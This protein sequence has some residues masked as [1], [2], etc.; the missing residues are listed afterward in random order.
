ME[1]VTTQL[2]Q[3]VITNRLPR[4]GGAQR[5][6]ARWALAD[7]CQSLL[8]VNLQNDGLLIY[9]GLKHKM[10]LCGLCARYDDLSETYSQNN[11]TEI[12]FY[13]NGDIPWPDNTFHTVLLHPRHDVVLKKTA[14]ELT[15]VIKPEGELLIA[16]P[17][18]P[19]KTLKGETISLF[20]FKNNRALVHL[21]RNLGFQ[22]VSIR[23]GSIGW[24]ILLA[25]KLIKR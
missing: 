13:T 12:M 6:F 14:R 20:Q 9:Y 16:L 3:R 8:E 23:M 15:R 18:L 5:A 4:L 19:I 11:G 24:G 2:K 7:D 25:R 10:R 1:T 22:D 21:L 17:W